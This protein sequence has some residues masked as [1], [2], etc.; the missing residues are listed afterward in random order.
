MENAAARTI[1][2]T[3]QKFGSIANKRVLIVCGSGNNGGDGAAIA[4]ML[5]GKG[6]AVDLLLL[7]RVEKTKGDARAN[8]EAAADIAN[9][10][11]SEFRFTEIETS[12]QFWSEA[13]A[14]HHDLFFDALLGTG[15]TRPATGIFEEA[16]HLLNEHSG[17][18]P[19]ISVDIPSG[20]G[21][22]SQELIGPAVKADLTVTFTAPKS[23]NIFPPAMEFCGE[24]VIVPIGSP[25]ELIN[26]TGS[27][28]NLVERDDVAGWLSASRR[29]P[30]ANKGDV[31]KVLIVAG[32]RG[33]TGAACLAGEAALRAG[34][35]L[36]TVAT[37]ESSQ[38][39]VASRIV[40]E[41][42]TEP[43]PETK[44][45]SVSREAA[46]RVIELAAERDVLAIGPGLGSTDKSTRALV[47]ALAMKR[48]QPVVIDADGL[49]SLAPWAKNL[50]GNEGLPM[51]LTPHPGEMAMLI[52]RPIAEIIRD[53]VQAARSFAMDQSVILVLKGSRTI[54]AAPDGQ[55]YV[56]TTGN[57]GMA[58]GGTGDVLTGIIASFLAQ[59]PDDPLSATIAAVYLHGLAGDIAAS[60]LGARAMIAS[61]ITAQLSESVISVGGDLEK[62]Q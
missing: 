49:N 9:K 5:H 2:A 58:T 26:S 6:T 45:G 27:R 28:L 16:V 56:N 51:I 47:R 24:L 59:R 15:L 22:D 50:A 17:D 18:R 3:E 57:A 10:S 25:E 1:E 8:F 41:C 4:R 32:S 62:G 43:L 19:V 12:E 54:T 13:S 35:G 39:I 23:G 53:P 34:C 29:S 31:G 55:V 46:D 11:A 60:K 30:H 37:A 14:H 40:P 20:V 48:G 52:S 38:P 7:G 33:K 36:V 21:S 42:M 44:A 61:D